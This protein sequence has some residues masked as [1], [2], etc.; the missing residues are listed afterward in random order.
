MRTDQPP[1]I[2]HVVHSLEGGGTERT[3]IALLRAFNPLRFRHVVVTLRGAGSLSERL[4][5]HVACRPL[6]A[7][8]RSWRSGLALAGLVRR[9]RTAIVHARGTGCWKDATVAKVLSPGVRLILGFHGLETGRA[10]DARQRRRARWGV[11]AGARFTSVSE[12][13][14]CQLGDQAGIPAQ[15]IETLPNGVDLRRFEGS[16]EAVRKRARSVWHIQDR[17]FVVGVVGSLTPVKRHDPLI[18]AVSGILPARPDTR[19]L[20]VGD[21]PERGALEGLTRVAGIAGRVTF[22]GW[23]E[24]VPALLSAMDVYVC[25]SASEGMNNSLLEALAAGLPVIATN[26]GDNGAVVRDNVEGFIVEPGSSAALAEALGALARRPDLCHRFAAASRRR[27][28]AYDFDRV[29]STYERFYTAVHPERDN[30][31]EPATPTAAGRSAD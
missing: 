14:R 12:A 11:W 31:P 21:G 16:N 17:T 19:L 24:D 1:L 5:D 18:R 20:I 9:R 29:V 28:E 27:A 7:L 2:V 22:T 23:R 3:L 15:R 10:F 30:A 6:G 26:V 4:P 13:G 8:G 25:C